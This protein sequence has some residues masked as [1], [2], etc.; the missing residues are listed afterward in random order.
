M[1]ADNKNTQYNTIKKYKNLTSGRRVKVNWLIEKNFL[2]LK[3]IISPQNK[4]PVWE[5]ILS[6]IVDAVK[7]WGDVWEW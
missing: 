1:K 7:F 4:S 3:K 6:S 5:P 2:N